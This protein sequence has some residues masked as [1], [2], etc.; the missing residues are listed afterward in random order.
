MK[1]IVFQSSSFAKNT[2]I[3]PLNSPSIEWKIGA[4]PHHSL[5]YFEPVPIQIPLKLNL[6]GHLKFNCIDPPNIQ[7][8]YTLEGSTPNHPVSI[9]GSSLLT[10]IELCIEENNLLFDATLEALS[11][12]IP[13]SYQTNHIKTSRA[14][15][16]DLYNETQSLKKPVFAWGG[17][18]K[19]HYTLQQIYPAYFSLTCKP[20][21]SHIEFHKNIDSSCQQ[22]VGNDHPH[23][24]TWGKTPYS[25]YQFI[26]QGGFQIKLKT[27][28]GEHVY[29]SEN[30]QNYDPETHEIQLTFT[31]HS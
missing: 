21:V 3:F 24:N 23:I 26:T 5:D 18:F 8:I 6:K 27:S 11:T 7:G 2:S 13:F 25:L 17:V 12:V 19:K 10:Q 4:Q 9:Y 29:I 31:S 14:Q 22:L 15:N 20:G 28:W 1:T 16:S 30:I